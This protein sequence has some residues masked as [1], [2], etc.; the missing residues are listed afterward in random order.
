MRNSNHPTRASLTPE[1]TR[2][3][4]DVV[5]SMT[6]DVGTRAASRES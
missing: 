6:G 4:L 2:E 3:D 1:M 5:G